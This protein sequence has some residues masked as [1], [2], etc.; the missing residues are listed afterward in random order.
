MTFGIAF[1]QGST[2]IP[3]FDMVALG[4][5]TWDT[6]S[7]VTG[8]VLDCSAQFSKVDGVID[9]GVSA[10]G[11]CGYIPQFVCA[12]GAAADTGVLACLAIVDTDGSYGKEGKLVPADGVNVAAIGTT[13]VMVIGKAA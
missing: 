10:I 8:E 6:T 3:G 5:I 7:L 2:P 1:D 12:K 9:I 4:T 11:L 13:R